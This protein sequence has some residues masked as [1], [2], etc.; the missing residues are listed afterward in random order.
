MH[1]KYKILPISFSIRDSKDLEFLSRHRDI[2]E[3]NLKEQN[4]VVS[5]AIKWFTE[6]GIH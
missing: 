3:H 4:S 6:E 5:P 1:V 2:S